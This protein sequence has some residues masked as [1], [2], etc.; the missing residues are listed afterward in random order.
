MDTGSAIWWNEECES[1][2]G[3]AGLSLLSVCEETRLKGF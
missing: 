3:E 2:G 1:G